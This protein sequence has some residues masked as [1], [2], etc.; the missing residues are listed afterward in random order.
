MRAIDQAVAEG[1]RPVA[2]GRKLEGA[3]YG[4]EFRRS[5]RSSTAC[6]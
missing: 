4:G 3:A 5:E 2:D 6:R 1:A